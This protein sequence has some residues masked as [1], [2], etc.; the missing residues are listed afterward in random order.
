MVPA[1]E[2]HGRLGQ[3]KIGIELALRR[4]P[5]RGCLTLRH[6]R[7]AAFDIARS[8]IDMEADGIVRRI[9]LRPRR[10]RHRKRCHRKHRPSQNTH[11]NFPLGS[12]TRIAERASIVTSL[13]PS[14]SARQG[15]LESWRPGN[16]LAVSER[17]SEAVVTA[18]RNRRFR[19]R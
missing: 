6:R 16:V 10:C 1:T 4:S 14:S 18:A 11:R 3:G 12:T 7:V 5:L 19:R 8:A 2:R 9:G 15:V 17:Q 13:E